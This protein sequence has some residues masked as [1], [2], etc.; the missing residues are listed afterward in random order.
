M[1]PLGYLLCES[2][3]ECL[4]WWD[5][6]LNDE[7][8]FQNIRRRSTKKVSWKCPY[9][10]SAFEKEV[11]YMVGPY[12]PVCPKC[13][14]EQIEKRK[15][16]WEEL[17]TTPVSDIPELLAAWDDDHDPSTI[18]VIPSPSFGESKNYRFKCPKGHH[19]RVEPFTYLKR[20]CPFCNSKAV[21]HPNE[22]YIADEFPE[23]AEEWAP[24]GNG[25]NTPYNTR[26]YSKKI[27]RWK[28][29]A[30]GFEWSET[31]RNRTNSYSAYCPNC[32]KILGS[33]AWKHP[34]LAKE[35]DPSNELTAWQ[36]RRFTDF[37]PS[38]ICSKN[39]DHRWKASIISRINGS[40]CPFCSNPS[41]SRIEKMYYEAVKKE[42]PSAESGV[43]VSDQSFSHSWIVDILIRTDN[44]KAVIE[45]DGEYWHKSKMDRDIEKS[46]ELL[47]AG[48]WVFRLRENG[49]LSL[50][51]NEPKYKE[52][53]VNPLSSK[54]DTVVETIKTILYT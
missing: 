14:Q 24:D 30:C 4:K 1:K 53:F 46:I 39:P 11:C 40:E 52:I 3:E 20:G 5:H 22:G 49:L 2:N 43:R 15:I 10:H 32:G 50:S 18:M 21:T 9:C 6:D 37:I 12:G 25:K 38:W 7:S 45:Y 31:P 41:Q 8:L 47:Q 51:I 29:L 23:L 19:P 26:H 34:D 33:L 48:F 16:E 54:I 44:L 28:C 13:R 17:H 42:F 36:V 27:I 35:W